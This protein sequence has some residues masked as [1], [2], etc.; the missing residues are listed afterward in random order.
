MKKVFIGLLILAAGT[1]VYF[2]I[3]NGRSPG[4][5]SIQK[6]LIIGKW[7]LDSIYSLKDSG[8]NPITDNAGYLALHLEKY[9]YEFTTS[10]SIMLWPTDSSTIEN[11]YE[12][13]DEN[14]LAWKEY[15]AGK[16]IEVFEVPVLN[17]DSMTLVAKD[18]VI[19]SFVKPN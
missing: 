15:P 17:V 12:W 19:L 4:K 9:E 7:K 14:Q 13:I 18:S 16:T 5:N 1:A 6:D 10:G 8:F 3:N 11:R 2:L